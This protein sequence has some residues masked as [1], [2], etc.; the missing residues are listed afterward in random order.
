M[1]TVLNISTLINVICL[2][3]VVEVK[4]LFNQ[5]LGVGEGVGMRNGLYS[6]TFYRDEEPAKHMQV[7]ARQ[8]LLLSSLS[9]PVLKCSLLH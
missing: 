3:L 1:V 2:S 4:V 7:Y 5:T 9:L 8:Q 6:L